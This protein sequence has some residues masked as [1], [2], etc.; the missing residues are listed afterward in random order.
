MEEVNMTQESF[1]IFVSIMVSK[2]KRL[3]NILH[4]K[5][6]WNKERITPSR[7]WPGVY[8]QQENCPKITRLKHLHVQFT[9]LTDH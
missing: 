1:F 9:Y 5:M 2:K 7:T 3:P 6:E 4:S 8:L